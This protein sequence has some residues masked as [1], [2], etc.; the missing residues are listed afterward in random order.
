MKAHRDVVFG[1]K[2]RAHQ[3]ATNSVQAP[4]AVLCHSLTDWSLAETSSTL[5]KGAQHELRLQHQMLLLLLLALRL[6]LLRV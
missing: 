6:L 2:F 5:E 4:S 1:V 3:I